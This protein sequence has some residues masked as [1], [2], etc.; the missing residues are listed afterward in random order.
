[1]PDPRVELVAVD[2][3]ILEQLVEV[4][5]TDAAADEVT[6]PLTG[7]PTWTA[8]RIAWLRE[9]HRSHRDGLAGQSVWAVLV[10]GAVAG[11]VRLERHD[12]DGPG[13]IGLWLAR[14]VR[15]RGVG[16]AVVHAVVDRAAAAGLRRVIAE[17]TTG[18]IIARRTLERAGFTVV[19]GGARGLQAHLDI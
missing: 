3:H 4:A 11:Q 19:A 1:M 9:F 10:D 17:T 18:N 8:Q 7:G 2:E 12:A 16:I 13:E 14:S 15:G 6:P 5:T